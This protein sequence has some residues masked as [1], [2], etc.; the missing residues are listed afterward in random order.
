MNCV[1][2]M[3]TC[4]EDRLS[5]LRRSGAWDTHHGRSNSRGLSRV[6]HKLL[7]LAGVGQYPR[8][9]LVTGWACIGLTVVLVFGTLF[10]YVQYRDLF[11]GI[12]HVAVTDL[13]K[14]PPR[15]TDA[16]NLLLIGS[17]SR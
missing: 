6:G 14:R 2:E 10:G 11:D 5:R 4:P 9:T 3:C 12:K 13:G 15:Y 16:L 7:E 17:D 8:R 1:F